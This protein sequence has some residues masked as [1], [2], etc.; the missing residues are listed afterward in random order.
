[1]LDAVGF[2]ILADGD[3]LPEA[4]RSHDERDATPRGEAKALDH[5]RTQ[6]RLKRRD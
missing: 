4:G 5:T 1:M 2:E 3:G 6:Y